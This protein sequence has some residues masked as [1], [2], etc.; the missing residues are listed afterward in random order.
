MAARPRTPRL[1]R[2]L[3]SRGFALPIVMLLAIVAGLTA[4]VMLMRHAAQVRTVQRQLDSYQTQHGVRGIQEIVGMWVSLNAG[5]D[6][7]DIVDP[8]GH[9]LTIFPGDGTRIE[10]R[11]FQASGRLL[12]NLDRVGSEL[13]P[14]LRDAARRLRDDVRRDTEYDRLTRAVGAPQ[15]AVQHARDEV[16]EAVIAAT[17]GT[18]SVAG[19]LGEIREG[20]DDADES[21]LTSNEI[22]RIITE[23]DLEPGPSAALARLLGVRDSLW[24]LEL[25][26]VG[27]GIN[28]TAGEIARYRAMVTVPEAGTSMSIPFLSWQE[29]TD[30]EGNNR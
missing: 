20:L 2:S 6:M 17:A 23:Q 24:E 22:G 19:I 8:D 30:A 25:R 10:I 15:I 11:I 13:R 18:G 29:I 3:G 21:S 7:E 9:A 27:T 28:I 26:V 5:R 1:P 4:S 16:L 12:D 14:T